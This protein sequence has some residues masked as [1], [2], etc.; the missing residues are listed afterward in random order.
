M[1]GRE[2]VDRRMRSLREVGWIIDTSAEDN[3]LANEELRVVKVG[4]HPWVEGYKWPPQSRVSNKVRRAVFDRDGNR[5]VVCGIAAG[6]MYP[7]D[8][9]FAKMTLGHLIPKG[10][11]G[12]NEL[13][14]LRTECQRCNE[15]SRHLTGTPVD[16]DLLRAEIKALRR[17]ERAELRRWI[18]DGRRS[19]TRTEALWAKYRQLPAIVR[20]DI[21]KLIE[22]LP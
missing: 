6:E 18:E 10:R 2:Q 15:T 11:K 9:K 8:R 7:D 5:C 1:P 12:T 16:A 4:D 20:D 17:A 19:F 13:A 21:R 3:T 14:N 22:A